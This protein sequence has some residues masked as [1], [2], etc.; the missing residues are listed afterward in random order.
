MV[1]LIGFRV[2]EAGEDGSI[3]ISFG[4]CKPLIE[5]RQVDPRRERV[6][7]SR[8][9]DHVDVSRASRA[10]VL[11]VLEPRQSYKSAARC[12]SGFSLLAAHAGFAVLIG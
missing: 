7:H 5:V 2:I 9:V 12:H 8:A 11:R 1:I 4:R 10:V 6:Q 3:A